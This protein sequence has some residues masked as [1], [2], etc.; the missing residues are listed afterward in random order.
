M[1]N[2]I[3]FVL[4]NYSSFSQNTLLIKL[5]NILHSLIVFYL[6]SFSTPLV[7]Y[8]ESFFGSNI[9]PHINISHW[10]CF[11]EIARFSIILFFVCSI[12]SFFLVI[13]LSTTDLLQYFH[14]PFLS[15]GIYL[16]SLSWK[17][18]LVSLKRYILSSFNC[19]NL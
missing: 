10:L 19:P 11:F 16:S 2:I 12:F 5:R 4:W 17:I 18:S 15:P 9:S 8:F 13:H 3:I 6:L 14:C 7:I 1:P